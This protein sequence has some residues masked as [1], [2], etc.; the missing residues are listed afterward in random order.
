MK[1]LFK[2]NQNSVLIVGDMGSG[3]THLAKALIEEFKKTQRLT[4]I[5]DESKRSFKEYLD[6]AESLYLGGEG[7]LRGLLSAYHAFLKERQKELG[8]KWPVG[9]PVKGL[10]VFETFDGT[11]DLLKKDKALRDQ[12]ELFLRTLSGANFKVVAVM[13]D[14]SRL[15]DRMLKL[16]HDTFSLKTKKEFQMRLFGQ[17]MDLKKHE[18]FNGEEKFVLKDL[19]GFKVHGEEEKNSEAFRDFELAL[20]KQFSS[21]KI[22]NL[23]LSLREA[24]IQAKGDKTNTEFSEVLQIHPSTLSH[25]L[26]G[27]LERFSVDAL[28]KL[29]EKS[30]LKV[31][32]TIETGKQED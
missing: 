1:T 10:I 26:S 13:K 19:F 2:E 32:L 11:L 9:E 29:A 5:H 31:S 22:L 28:L 17:A 27:D 16:F 18:I 8:G 15:D 20:K 14:L 6:V 30:G 12:F 4:L 25:L 3:K 21:D 7:A 23:K 24:L